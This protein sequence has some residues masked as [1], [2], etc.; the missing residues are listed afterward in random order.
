MSASLEG[1]RIG[2]NAVPLLTPLTGIGQY[3]LHLARAMQELL[4][5]KPFLFYASEWDREIRAAPVAPRGGIVASIKGMVPWGYE[6][7]RFRQ[8]RRFAAGARAHLL[9]LYHETNYLAFPFDG[10]MVV[11]VHDLSWVRH[12]ETHPAD[13]VRMMDK[14]MP[15]V[16][17]RA[18]Q[19]VVDSEFSRAEVIEHY[20]VPAER[21]TTVLLGVPPEFRPIDPVECAPFLASQGL[22]HGEYVLAV[23]TLEPR[24][25][26][27]TAVAAFARLPQPL[28]ARYPLV[29]AGMAGW[30]M[31]R[32]PREMQRMIA[33]GEVRLLGYVPQQDLPKLY[34]GAR[35]FVYPSI[36]E[37]FGLP[38]LEAMACGVPVIVSRRASLPEVVGEA[39]VLVEPLDEAVM[40]ERMHEL[41]EDGDARRR[42]SAAG[43]A[44]ASGF[45]WRRCALETIAIY[46]KALGPIGP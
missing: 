6:I 3:T 29:V 33:G 11:T 1:V 7:A 14:T 28:R 5:Q 43:I 17:E 9:G 19:V 38:P 30:K 35:L 39:G 23:G 22:K 20:R 25:N 26:L 24:K 46:K 10:P 44:R 15:G 40:A 2:I 21:V 31:D 8:Q 12:P 45:T 13:R 34:S 18:A 42:L 16:L 37:G 32:L 36:Y 41:L 4:P 27:A